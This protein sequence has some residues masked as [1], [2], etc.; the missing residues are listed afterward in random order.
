MATKFINTT[1][2]KGGANEFMIISRQMENK[3]KVAL[4][5]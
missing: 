2:A 5:E 4:I 3:P 1:S